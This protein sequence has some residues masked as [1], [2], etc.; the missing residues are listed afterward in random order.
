MSN[1]P[2]CR[3]EYCAISPLFQSEY[4]VIPIIKSRC[5]ELRMY[6]SNSVISFKF[7]KS[8][9]LAVHARVLACVKLDLSRCLPFRFGDRWNGAE[10]VNQPVKKEARS[11]CETMIPSSDR[12]RLL[13]P[14]RY[15]RPVR[16]SYYF[17]SPF[18]AY[19]IFIC[20]RAD[21]EHNSVVLWRVWVVAER[22]SELKS[23]RNVDFVSQS[24]SLIYL[25]HC[26]C[27]YVCV[28]V[29][30]YVPLSFS[31]S[32]SM[33]LSIT[34]SVSLSLSLCFTL[35]VSVSFSLSVCLSISI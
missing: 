20:P 12:L 1:I 11:S 25:F 27:M 23:D 24:L 2:L 8:A 28:C 4:I 7:D 21:R 33:S 6:R 29:C 9:T 10:I 31:H 14:M 19:R 18:A 30:M 35:F 5:V 22:V 15:Y 16:G 3:S 13:T 17:S 32:L 26:V 34:H